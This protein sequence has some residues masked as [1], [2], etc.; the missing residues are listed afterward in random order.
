ML[1][2]CGR[3]S[4]LSFT[5]IVIAIVIL[6]VAFTVRAQGTGGGQR[7]MKPSAVPEQGDAQQLSISPLVVGSLG[8]SE[9]RSDIITSN[10][11]TNA[12]VFM[13]R[14]VYDSGGGLSQFVASADLNND[15]KPDLAVVNYGSYGNGT[16]GIL[17]GK[18][19]GTFWPD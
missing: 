12:P 6:V 15:G 1:R 8:A 17:V 3:N 10:L 2:E 4:S 18:G 14:A 11:L 7:L 5:V 19:N 16:V 13:R 9:D